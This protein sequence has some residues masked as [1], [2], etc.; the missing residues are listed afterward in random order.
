MSSIGPHT[1]E[2]STA[3]HEQQHT[4]STPAAHPPPSI[5]STSACPRLLPATSTPAC[6]PAPGQPPRRTCLPQRWQPPLQGQPVGGEPHRPQPRQRR[7]PAHQLWQ[8]G[9]Q[10]GLAPREPDLIHSRPH[11]EARLRGEEDGRKGELPPT[12]RQCQSGALAT[13][14]QRGG[15]PNSV[16]NSQPA[17][18]QTQ[19]ARS[20]PGPPAAALRQWRA[21]WGRG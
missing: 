9:P 14:L 1:S 12:G 13:V 6:P 15:V 11:K 3:Q 17:G 7:Q 20:Q 21:G 16:Q 8:V 10:C 2:R 4:G 5:S 19:P 18:N